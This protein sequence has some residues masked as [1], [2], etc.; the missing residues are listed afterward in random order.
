MQ[1]PLIGSAT[2]FGLYIVVKLVK[3]EY[4]DMLISLYFSVLGSFSVFGCCAPHLTEALGMGGLKRFEFKFNW[5]IWKKAENREP[6]E[7]GFSFFDLGVFSLCAAA[8]IAYAITK[9]WYLNNLLGCAFALQGI[10]MLALGSYAIVRCL[11]PAASAT[12]PAFVRQLCVA[13]GRRAHRGRPRA[14]GLVAQ[15]VILLCGLFLY[16]VFWVFGTEVMVSVAKG[17]NAPVKILFPKALG[18]KP[19]PC[20]MLGLGDI[21]IPV[22][23]RPF[24]ARRQRLTCPTPHLPHTSPASRLTC[25]TPPAPRLTCL[26]QRMA[27]Y[28]RGAHAS[29]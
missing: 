16:D 24:R 10:E 1:F 2:L 19:I 13:R 20:S 9:K 27:G 17:L 21:V 4:L 7:F 14:C 11:P 18:V 23:P 8:S 29:L 22:R 15:G 26:T 28:L 5:Q 6:L 12:G 25:P 3:K